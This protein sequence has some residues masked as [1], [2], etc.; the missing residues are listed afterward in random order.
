M[1]RISVVIATCDRGHLLPNVLDGLANQQ[2]A[3]L[4]V[5][6]VDSS[7]SFVPL[8]TEAFEFEVFH[9]H[10][11]QRSLTRQRNEGVAFLDRS[12]L[13]GTYVS[14]LDDDTVPRPDWISECVR[15]L[16]DGGLRIVGCSGIDGLGQR[17]ESAVKRS[18]RGVFG[19]DTRREGVVLRSGL[20]SAVTTPG[21]H[22]V[23]WLFGCSIW[24]SKIY[25]SIE[26]RPDFVGI[27]LGEDVEFSM[28]AAKYGELWVLPWAVLDHSRAGEGRPDQILH[29]YRLVRSRREIARLRDPSVVGFLAWAWGALGQAVVVA[30]AV[31]NLRSESRTDGWLALRGCVAGFLDGCRNAPL[32]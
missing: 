10:S 6:I 9:I 14:I 19:L 32:R 29:H 5:V 12:G 30:G 7:E 28:R 3:P 27:S 22:Q 23:E 21:V 25:E 20:N 1:S 31:L 11:D 17:N 2:V 15:F 8:T 4:A 13:L 26:Y 24:R 16:E 18:I